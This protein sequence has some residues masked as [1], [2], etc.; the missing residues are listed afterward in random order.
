MR[1]ALSYHRQENLMTPTYKMTLAA[2]VGAALGAAAVQGLQPGG[3]EL[4]LRGE[5]V[6]KLDVVENLG[7]SC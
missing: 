3:V 2:L 6:R 1:G 7:S 4:N 5:T